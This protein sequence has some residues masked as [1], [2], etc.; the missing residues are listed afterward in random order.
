M[1]R[2][3]EGHRAQPSACIIDSQSVKTSIDVPTAGQGTDAGKKIVGRKRH[4]VTD[5]LRLLPAVPVTAASAPDGTAGTQLLTG[6]AAT[7]PTIS[8]TWADTAYRTK[9]IDHAANPGID[10]ETIRRDP[11][12]KGFVPLPRRW[13]VERTFDRLMLHRRL[14]RDYE[15]LP[16]RS[17]AMIHVA[18]IDL[19]SRRLTGEATVTW[20][21]T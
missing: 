11:T 6:V 19:T 14:A 12:T 17:E 21:G 13:V 16:T 8:K 3:Q 2:E 10:L 5:T 18:M 1:V 7:Y 4:I 15:T 20:R 9:A